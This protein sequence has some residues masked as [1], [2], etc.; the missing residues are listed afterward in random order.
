MLIKRY[1]ECIIC[2]QPRGPNHSI[3]FCASLHSSTGQ[4]PDAN[5]ADE[6]FASLPL[7]AD[8]KKL[9]DSMYINKTD[10]LL[11][12]IIRRLPRIQTHPSPPNLTYEN[13]PTS[14]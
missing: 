8:I 10:L 12:Q 13:H 3:M 14:R 11:A 2:G 9:I 7:D 5:A 1:G 4:H 6:I